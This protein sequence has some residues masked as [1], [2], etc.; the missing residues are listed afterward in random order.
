MKDL[1]NIFYML[2]TRRQYFQSFLRQIR[3]IFI[4]LGQTL[5]E[6]T[7]TNSSFWIIS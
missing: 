5:G 3:K 4:T 6:T 2:N 7:K 1:I